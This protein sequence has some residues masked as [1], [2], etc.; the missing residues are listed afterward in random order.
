[1]RGYVLGP[2]DS[3]PAGAIGYAAPIFASTEA[4][5]RFCPVFRSGL[6]FAGALTAAT[7]MRV[8]SMGETVDIAPFV[9]PVTGWAAGDAPDCALMAARYNVSGA[10]TLLRRARQTIRAHGGP[11]NAGLSSGPFI[12]TVHRKGGA[13]VLFDLSQAP[14][15]D[16]RKW[17]D[18]AVSDLTDP[19]AHTTQVIRPVPRDRVRAFVFNSVDSWIG[20]LA[21]L[22]PGYA[23]R[24]AQG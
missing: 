10:Q 6:T 15:Q 16:Y 4:A 17:L 8:L 23:A 7:P 22:I 9:W 13:V 18:R 5:A 12:M 14:P 3:V 2:S 20:V 21:V 24:A 11:A 1:M 19:G